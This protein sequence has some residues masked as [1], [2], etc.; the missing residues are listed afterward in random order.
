MSPHELYFGKKPNFAHFRVFGS[1][2]YVHVPKEKRRKLD[3][4]AKKC[5][6]VHYSDEN[7]GD[8]FYNPRSKEFRVSR[9]ILFDK[10]T[11]WYLPLPKS[12]DEASKAEMILDEEDIGTLDE[13]P[14]SFW[15][16]G[17]NEELSRNSQPIDM[18][19]SDEASSMLS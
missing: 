9:D 11:S 5:I 19:T 12:Q 4:K 15:L 16:S 10:S 2:S 17:L 13:S 8:K 7:K 18:L 6:L 3:A 1:I 14:I